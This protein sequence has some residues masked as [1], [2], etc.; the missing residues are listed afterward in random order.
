MIDLLWSI[1]ESK[2]CPQS[3][4]LSWKRKKNKINDALT[5]KTFEEKAVDEKKNSEGK[6]FVIKP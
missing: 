1:A 2:H 6:K 3:Q 4:V 5:N